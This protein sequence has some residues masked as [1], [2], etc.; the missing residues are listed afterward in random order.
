[1]K[2]SQFTITEILI[3]LDSYHKL[4]DTRVAVI[5]L[6]GVGSYAVEA[7]AR[8]GI[9]KF[10]IIDFDVVN[11]SNLNRQLLAMHSTIGKSKTTLM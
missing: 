8:A 2:Y 6:G 3:G 1:M 4:R 10:L 5:G 9:G 7:L 11:L